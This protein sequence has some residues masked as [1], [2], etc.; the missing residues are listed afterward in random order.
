[1]RGG[2]QVSLA[3]PRDPSG[4]AW[5]QWGEEDPGPEEAMYQVPLLGKLGVRGL[6]VHIPFGPSLC[7]LLLQPLYL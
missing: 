3:L 4:A 5:M 1:M 7:H 6:L 2:L